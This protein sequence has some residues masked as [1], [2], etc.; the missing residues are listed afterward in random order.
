MLLMHF[1]ANSMK[2][3]YASAGHE[4]GWLLATDGKLHELRSTGIML[5]VYTEMVFETKELSVRAGDRLFAYTDGLPETFNAKGECLGRDSLP[6]IF[7]EARNL[8]TEEASERIK[9][10]G[11]RHRE[12]GA[13][14]DDVTFFVAE[15]E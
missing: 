3:K 10:A 14:H 6:D 13:L 4:S 11:D 8:S 12:S 1:D 2:L 5:G 15:F 9:Q 7:R